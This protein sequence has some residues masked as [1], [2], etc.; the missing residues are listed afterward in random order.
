MYNFKANLIPYAEKKTTS[1]EILSSSQIF[2]AINN[3]VK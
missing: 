2:P 3:N 1:I